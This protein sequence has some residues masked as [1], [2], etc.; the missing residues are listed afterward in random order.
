MQQII[1]IIIRLSVFLQDVSMK[2]SIPAS[3]VLGIF[4]M[5]LFT[6]RDDLEKIFSEYG[7]IEKVEL[8][9]NRQVS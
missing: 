6:R 7:P 8:I 2:E 3:R 4:G 9:L 1:I 5:S